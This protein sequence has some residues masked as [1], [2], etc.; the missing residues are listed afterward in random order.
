MA[1][2]INNVDLTFVGSENALK[3]GM[4]TVLNATLSQFPAQ[5]RPILNFH[6]I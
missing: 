1:A 2:P 3:G 5:D 4:T 6:D